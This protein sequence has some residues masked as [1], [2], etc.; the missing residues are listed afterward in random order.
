MY[1]APQME[2]WEAELHLYLQVDS[3]TIPGG[4]L[5]QNPNEDDINFNPINP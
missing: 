5:P 3:P 4:I 2:V 1:E